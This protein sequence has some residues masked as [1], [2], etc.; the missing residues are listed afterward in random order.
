MEEVRVIDTVESLKGLDLSLLDRVFKQGAVSMVRAAGSG[1]DGACNGA[2][3]AC[4]RID[5]SH[6]T[7]ADLPPRVAW[8]GLPVGYFRGSTLLVDGGELGAYWRWGGKY[9]ELVDGKNCHGGCGQTGR[10]VNL[11]GES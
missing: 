9:F 4:P 10:V 3:A 2:T 7:L 8:Q 1:G 6:P 11:E 5:M